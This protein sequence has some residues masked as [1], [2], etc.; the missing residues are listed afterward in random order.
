MKVIV[1]IELDYGCK[2]IL[3]KSNH[4][5]TITMDDDH[6]GGLVGVSQFLGLFQSVVNGYASSTVLH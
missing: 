1:R 6:N 3:T 5:I 4:I 2:R